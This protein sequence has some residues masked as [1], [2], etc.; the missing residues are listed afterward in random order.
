[1][2]TTQRE[3]HHTSGPLYSAHS[4]SFPTVSSVS[5][6]IGKDTGLGLGFGGLWLGRLPI[7]TE[8]H[9]DGVNWS[10]SG[11]K[12]VI[13]SFHSSVENGIRREWAGDEVLH[14]AEDV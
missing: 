6:C 14:R 3:G 1:M 13:A 5:I 8:Q 7:Y 4:A 11:G 10:L 9:S 12:S 2:T